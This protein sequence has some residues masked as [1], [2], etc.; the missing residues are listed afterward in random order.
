MFR[1]FFDVETLSIYITRLYLVIHKVSQVMSFQCKSCQYNANPEKEGLCSVCYKEAN[2]P[3]SQIKKEA[4]AKIIASNKMQK[5]LDL[6]T[7]TT[8][9]CIVLAEA[10][11]SC[12][13]YFLERLCRVIRKKVGL[14]GIAEIVSSHPKCVFTAEQ[15][16]Q[17]YNTVKQTSPYNSNNYTFGHYFYNRVLDTWNIWGEEH[18]SVMVCY[19]GDMRTCLEEAVEHFNCK[20]FPLGPDAVNIAKARQKK[21]QALLQKC[22][23]A[24]G[25]QGCHSNFCVCRELC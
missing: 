4:I 2:K 22:Q 13:S 6:M 14:A 5:F 9:A 19:H 18:D 25:E 21:I 11:E 3:K 16:C 23:T 24:G 15:A 7:E 8:V 10:K 20:I 17:L 12:P 1:F